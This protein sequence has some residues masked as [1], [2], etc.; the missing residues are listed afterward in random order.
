MVNGSWLMAVM[1]AVTACSGSAAEWTGWPNWRGPRC[2]G[3]GI[4]TGAKMAESFEE[5]TH[6]W[7]NDERVPGTYEHDA[8]SGGNRLKTRIP[9][10]YASPVVA[11]GRVYLAYYVPNGPVYDKGVAARVVLKAAGGHNQRG[12]R[13]GPRYRSKVKVKHSH[14][15]N[16]DSA[17]RHTCTCDLSLSLLTVPERAQNFLVLYRR[18]L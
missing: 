5:A 17:F 15:L 1:L 4:D 2:D 18:G 11:D 3:S 10:G 12:H 16:N 9:A 7:T 6:L 14:N 13:P 8:R